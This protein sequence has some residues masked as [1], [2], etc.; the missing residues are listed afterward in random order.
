[1]ADAPVA[2]CLTC[3]TPMTPE[4]SAVFRN[5]AKIAHVRCWTLKDL[6]PMRKADHG[7]RSNALASD[8]GASGGAAR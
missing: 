7:A 5:G 3:R 4:E 1:M 8:R 6:T 2:N